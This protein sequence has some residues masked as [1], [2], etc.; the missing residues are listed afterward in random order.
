MLGIQNS[1]LFVWDKPIEYQRGDTW[2]P[3]PNILLKTYQRKEEA[4]PVPRTSQKISV[5]KLLEH[6]YFDK[7]ERYSMVVLDIF[8][9]SL[10][11]GLYVCDLGLENLHYIEYITYQLSTAIRTLNLF[12]L[13]R[14]TG[15]KL[16]E[17]M[18]KLQANNIALDTM[19]KTD[20]LTGI[21]N[22]RGFYMAAEELL[23]KSTAEECYVVVC[24][25]DM[26]KL[27]MVNDTYGHDEGDYSLCSCAKILQRAMKDKGIVGRIGGDEFCAIALE[28]KDNQEMKYRDRIKAVTQLI[29]SECEKPYKIELSVGIAEFLNRE[30]VDLQAMIDETDDL[31]YVEKKNK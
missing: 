2:N 7:T 1:Y 26:D 27:K 25:A 20:E 3:P 13:Q 30:D 11:L 19:S 24:Y 15:K 4:F 28:T 22:R 14:I 16:E 31:L 5:R 23:K 6:K 8:S 9:Q 10:Q 17:S 18:E 12:Q 21:Y 29:N